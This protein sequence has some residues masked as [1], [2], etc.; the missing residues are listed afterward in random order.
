VGQFSQQPHR[1]DHRCDGHDDH[2]LDFLTSILELDQIVVGEAWVNTAKKGQTGTFSRLWGS[3]ASLLYVNPISANTRSM[4][5]GVTAQWG[6]RIAGTHEDPNLGLKGG[7]RVRV[8]EEVKELVL[9]NDLGYLFQN[10]V[11]VS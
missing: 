9:A 7:I 1:R 3:H 5:F 10:A 4:T 2:A 11:S 6:D 8:G